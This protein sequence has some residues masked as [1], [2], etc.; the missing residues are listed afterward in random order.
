MANSTRVPLADR[1][2]LTYD[3]VLLKP[4]YSQNLPSE[5]I[6]E[7][8]FSKNIDLKMPIVSAAMDT[9]T[10]SETAIVM[11][12]NGGIGVIHKNLSPE[13]QAGEVRKVKKYESGMI[14]D[15]IT[16]GPNESLE[17]VNN[18]TRRH[19]IT[20]VPVV[21]GSNKLIGILTS[22]DLRFETNF[23]QKVSDVMT[24]LER[25]VT[26]EEGVGLD[27]AK[28]LLH[29]HRIEKLPVVT[30]E[31]VL[32]GLITIKD[33][34]KGIDFP[35]SNKDELGRLRAAAAIGVGDK[36]RERA[37]HLFEAGVDAIIVDTA[38]GHSKGVI[39][40]VQD[41]KKNYSELEV[42]AG[43][44]A[45][46]AA[47]EDLIKAGVSAVKVGIGPGSICT[48]RVVAGIGVPQLSAILDCS[49]VCREEGIP[50]IADGGIKYSGD[51]VKALAAGANTV[52]I[53]SLFAGTD[54]TPGERIL[55]QGRSYKVYR[56]MGSLGAMVMGSKDR[57]GQGAVDDLGKLVPEGIEGQVPYRG[58]LSSNIYQ[59]LGGLRAGMGYVGA[60]TLVELQEKAQFIQITSAS[61]KESHP[62][63]VIITKEAPNYSK[64]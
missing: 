53:G 36:E 23:K 60:R 62:H 52:M 18:I 14:I 40:M 58:S 21:D 34:L 26:A 43:N 19:N 6:L 16:V 31:G 64:A 5:T 8:K 35:N 57:Y 30:K 24:P 1:P 47:C 20:G 25:L 59:L 3:D 50:F 56:G 28:N 4:G 49:A 7:T 13:D 12:Q 55:Y 45:T 39:E 2:Y 9:V 44:V 17:A 33:I 37:R 15:P 54:E 29:K 10:E 42:I 51:V 61:L 46:G 22:R 32:K 41:L 48:T 11:A 63:D 27:E 38:H